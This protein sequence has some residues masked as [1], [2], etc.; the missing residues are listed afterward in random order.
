[1]SLEDDAKAYNIGNTPLERIARHARNP[2]KPL[3]EEDR[4]LFCSDL[5]A[6][7]NRC[8]QAR[9]A[10]ATVRLSPWLRSMLQLHGVEFKE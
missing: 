2:D 4:D 5:A 8:Y 10:G 3:T 9:K 7:K 1:M 6:I